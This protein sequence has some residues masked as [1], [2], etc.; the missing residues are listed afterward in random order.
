M[1]TTIKTEALRWFLRQPKYQDR[2]KYITQY[3]LRDSPK[4]LWSE[5]SKMYQICIPVISFY[6]LEKCSDCLLDILISLYQL[7]KSQKSL[8]N[9]DVVNL[10]DE[11]FLKQHN[12]LSIFQNPKKFLD[13]LANIIMLKQ[14]DDEELK[15][16]EQDIKV[17][18]DSLNFCYF[19]KHNISQI[20]QKLS[21]KELNTLGDDYRELHKICSPIINFYYPKQCS[22]E[23]LSLL[24]ELLSIIKNL[25][26]KW[27]I[28]EEENYPLPSIGDILIQQYQLS[29]FSKI[30]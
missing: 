3:S 17:A 22:Q 21:L 18:V 1:Q 27:D 26:F 16:Y 2:L 19:N 29:L 25:Q 20:E 12:Q 9:L 15:S 11:I 24:R 5:Y 4:E 6:Y 8:D 30:I 28:P 10:K 13:F 23:L 14:L 7:I